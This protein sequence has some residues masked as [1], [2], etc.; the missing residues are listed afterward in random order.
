M[1]LPRVKVWMVA[2]AVIAASALTGVLTWVLANAPS[3]ELE[4]TVLFEQ[5]RSKEL[6]AQVGSLSAEASAAVAAA[7]AAWAKAKPAASGPEEPASATT[8]SKNFTSYAYIRKMTG[9]LSETF[10][11]HI[12]TFQVLNGTEAVKYAKAHGK[13]VPSNGILVVNESTKTTAY[14]LAGT[15]EITAYTGGV[16][17]MRP[18]P[19]DGGLLKEWV[20]D[21]SA[22]PGA[23]SDMWEVTVKNGVITTIEMIAIAG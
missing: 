9:P 16:E 14:P 7:N 22:V 3:P 20:S 23:S 15:A 2:L 19:I 12:D 8:S 4:A 6:S 13:T 1:G 18:E 10:T 5:H 21:P 11:V 17:A